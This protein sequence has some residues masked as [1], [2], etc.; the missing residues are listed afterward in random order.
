M[1]WN[2]ITFGMITTSENAKSFALKAIEAA[3]TKNFILADDLIR[4][5]KSEI[6]ASKKFHMEVMAAEA[7]NEKI[8]YSILY[9]HSKD[10]LSSAE[11]I[12]LMSEQIID[13]WKDKK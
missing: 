10:H 6:V 11:T 2:A 7:S 1:D 8:E 3:K 9:V 12:I 4:T 13:L 5:A